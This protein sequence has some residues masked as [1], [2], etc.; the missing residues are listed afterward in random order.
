MFLT[1]LYVSIPHL[2]LSNFLR[3]FSPPTELGTPNDHGENFIGLL[4]VFGLEEVIGNPWKPMVNPLKV[5]TPLEK[6]AL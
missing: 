2:F 4:K 1:P 3:D 5:P 6:K